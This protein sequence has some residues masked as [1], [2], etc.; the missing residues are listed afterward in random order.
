MSTVQKPFEIVPEFNNVNYAYTSYQNTVG[1]NKTNF[2][3]VQ[4]LI[5]LQNGSKWQDGTGQHSAYTGAGAFGS[6]NGIT[7]TSADITLDDDGRITAIQN[8]SGGGGGGV[9]NPMTSDLDA[10]GFSIFDVDTLSGMDVTLTGQLTTQEI[11]DSAAV[12]YVNMGAVTAGNEYTVARIGSLRDAEGSVTIVS[13]CLDVGFKQTIVFVLTAFER[14]ANANV[15][16]NLV[17]SDTPIFEALVV[18]DDGNSMFCNLRC[19][20]PSS[21]W[22][23]RAYMNQDDKGTIGVYGDS[24]RL[25]PA[26]TISPPVPNVLVELRLGFQPEGQASMSGDLDVRDGINCSTVTSSVANT[27]VLN[28]NVIDNLSSGAIAVN[29]STSIIANGTNYAAIAPAGLTLASDQFIG[30]NVA[31]GG[32]LFLNVNSNFTTT[33]AEVRVT[34]GDMRFA[35]N[36]GQPSPRILDLGDPINAQDAATKNYVDSTLGTGY[37]T[38]PMTSDLDGGAFDINNVAIINE[39]T[40][41]QIGPQPISSSSVAVRLYGDVN[42]RFYK[43]QV[44]DI[45]TDTAGNPGSMIGYNGFP[46]SNGASD[47]GNI[48]ELNKGA[49][50]TGAFASNSN[51]RL[52]SS[53][54]YHKMT[55]LGE[56]LFITNP[57]FTPGPSLQNTFESCIKIQRS[58]NASPAPVL[59]NVHYT[60]SEAGATFGAPAYDYL[61]FGNSLQAQNPSTTTPALIVDTFTKK[62]GVGIFPTEDFEVDGNI[63]LDSGSGTNSIKFYDTAGAHDHAQITAEDDGTNGG[64]FKIKTKE[65]GGTLRDGLIIG[66]D[67]SVTIPGAQITTLQG[68][69]IV[70]DAIN[71]PFQGQLNVWLPTQN[72]SNSG[73]MPSWNGGYLNPQGMGSRCACDESVTAPGANKLNAASLIS[74]NV[75]AY[76]LATLS[77]SNIILDIPPALDRHI[78]N[79]QVDGEWNGSTIGGN[80]NSYMYIREDANPAAPIIGLCTG[81][82][83]DGARYPLCLNFTG[84]LRAGA[85]AILIGHYDL[86]S[87]RDYTGSFSIKYIGSF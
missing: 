46:K 29:G 80:G 12:Q 48:I 51:L 71:N 56:T 35:P 5:T 62:V 66:Q 49:T 15:L 11:N 85:Y 81:Q 67:T 79:V 58:P 36:L 42:Y 69:V 17:E 45:P 26:A 60:W 20:A 86:G 74:S 16:V 23:V 19:S 82:A 61:C 40:D 57:V 2:P 52:E 84:S 53:H 6:P 9:Q 39:S 73:I 37:V 78:F 18:G 50:S 4:G 43:S 30:V 83:V 31:D 33:N 72:A 10:N 65:D 54:E 87:N 24:W 13:R 7:Y 1:A 32:N 76:T 55:A 8:G 22:E 28:V 75:A 21:T 25:A 27:D 70:G 41:T 3:I 38:N 47:F 59:N 14:K 34:G 68:D 64:Q 44:S 63:Q 77:G